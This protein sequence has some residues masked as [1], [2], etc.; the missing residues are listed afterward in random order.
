LVDWDGLSGFEQGVD[1]ASV[2]EIGA[3]EPGKFE[4]TVYRFLSKLGHA[5]DEKRDQGDGYLN[6]NCILGD[7]NKALD[8]K[9]LLDPAEEQF[10]LPA[11]FVELCDLVCRRVEVVGDDTATA[12]R[13]R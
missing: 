5:Q 1:W 8:S 6:T 4:R 12:C 3:D 13:S 11:L 10:D 2:H 9:R 7:A